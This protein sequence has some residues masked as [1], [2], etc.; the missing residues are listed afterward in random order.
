MRAI[1][2]AWAQRFRDWAYGLPAPPIVRS[3]AA[4]I[5]R[6]FVGF[7]RDDGSHLAAGVAYYAIFSLFPLALAAIAF[8]GLF[9]TPEQ[10]EARV[11]DVLGEQ[12]PGIGQGEI[13][14]GNIE[15]LVQAR[16]ALGAIAI[17]ALLWSSRAVFGAVHRVMNRAWGVRE[18]QHFLV[19]QVGQVAGAAAVVALFLASAVLGTVGRAIV[20]RTDLL[21]GGDLQVGTL[22][23]VLP[24]LTTLVLLI[25]I[26]KVL[27]DASVRW[28]DAALAAVVASVLFELSK[29]LF[30]YYLGNL[31]ALDLV[32][33]S[34]TT[35]VA[36]MLFLYVAS[37]VLVLGAELSSEYNRLS[38]AGLVVFRGHMRPVRGGL[39]P[40]AWRQTLEH[41]R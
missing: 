9:I 25:V 21:L 6:S 17:I 38:R 39:A 22:V 5:Y 28:R 41:A 30:A 24:F 2:N 18:A 4:L 15:A 14:R 16:G 33:G 3:V 37:M 7:S 1:T 34:V 27:P 19:Y 23:T 11:I 29:I 12:L 13:I 8:G 10:I 26:Y 31:S 40:P 36:L 20:A 32:Y 35:V